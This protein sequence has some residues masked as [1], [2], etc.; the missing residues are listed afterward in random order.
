V[1]L[2]YL[3]YA[4]W[5]SPHTGIDQFFSLLALESSDILLRLLGYETVPLVTS[6]EVTLA[7]QGTEGVGVWIGTACNGITLFALFAIY[8]LSFPG[9]KTKKLWYIPLGIVA[10][11]IINTIRISG[12]AII[13]K[14][15]RSYLDFNH[16]YTFQI[17]AYGVVFLLWYFWTVKLSNVL[18]Q[19]DQ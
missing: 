9:P 5:L 10:I 19:R 3:L 17:L 14:N 18:N 15:Y 4:L 1:N 16:T 13:E 8:I 11:H 2:W 6:N 12:L 7:L